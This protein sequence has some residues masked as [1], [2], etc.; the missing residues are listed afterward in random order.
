MAANRHSQ[1]VQT[2]WG[3]PSLSWILVLKL[4]MVSIYYSSESQQNPPH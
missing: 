2:I 1:I 4:S 3:I